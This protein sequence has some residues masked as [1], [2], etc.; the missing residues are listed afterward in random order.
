MKISYRKLEVAN[1]HGVAKIF[2]TPDH[3]YAYA[4]TMSRSNF[5]IMKHCT[6]IDRITET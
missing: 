1:F 3:I 5:E 4:T 6:P 2:T